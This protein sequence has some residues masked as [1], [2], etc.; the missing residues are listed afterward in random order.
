MRKGTALV[1]LIL[2][3]CGGI[4]G[5]GA[6]SATRL[7]VSVVAEPGQAPATFA[8]EC[9]TR[10]RINEGT[11]PA[12]VEPEAACALV[13]DP[14]NRSRLVDGPEP[15]QICTEIYGGPQIATVRG[16]VRG[17]AVDA[18]FDR[19]NGCGIADWDRFEPLLGSPDQSVFTT[20]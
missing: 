20:P 13:E 8:L 9:G 10:P 3:S 7:E 14:D 2:A 19:A 15:M 4:E 17:D 18:R 1:M 5:G 16:T 6:G 12:E 11:P